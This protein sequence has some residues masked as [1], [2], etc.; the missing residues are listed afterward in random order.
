[1]TY[2]EPPMAKA[3]PPRPVPTYDHLRKK[4][5]L[6]H[7]VR[8]PL[9]EEAVAAHREATEALGRA[10]LALHPM[11]SA[12]RAGE[13]P[14]PALVTARDEQ[15]RAKAAAATAK[16]A[17]EDETV[18]MRFR[19]IGR[20]S[21]DAL[22]RDHPP[23]DTTGDD[24]KPAKS[25]DPYDVETFAPALIA[26]SCV[27]PRMTYAQVLALFDLDRLDDD[28]L[29]DLAGRYEVKLDGSPTHAELVAAVRDVA[30]EWN[31]AEV[32][33]L[34]IAALAC[35][36]QRRVADFGNFSNGTRG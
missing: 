10:E 23:K 20:P 6:E 1:M 8:V 7:V 19:S 14:G 24:G 36:T 9:S 33:D 15:D 21:Y 18:V 31:S 32:M 13:E 25:T 11:E 27:E 17:L 2:M 26:A 34:W 5:P 29:T 3:A 12:L 16:A 28:D 4:A 22:V 30:P 35:N